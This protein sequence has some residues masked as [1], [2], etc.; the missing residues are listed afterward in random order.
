MF[1]CVFVGICLCF[2]CVCVCLRVCVC[3]VVCVFVCACGRVCSVQVFFA[4]RPDDET[5]GMTRAME[6]PNSG[7][8]RGWAGRKRN[9]LNESR[10]CV[11]GFVSMFV[12]VCFCLHV[13][14]CV[15]F[16]VC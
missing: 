15:C 5:L 16:F 7:Q 10:T 9:T 4:R 8:T 12:F 14:V 11:F 1:V 6:R 13:C 2:V 3:V